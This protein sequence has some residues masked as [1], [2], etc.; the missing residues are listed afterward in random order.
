MVGLLDG[1]FGAEVAAA[2][3]LVGIVAI[4]AGTPIV[5]HEYKVFMG[6]LK[7]RPNRHG[8][9]VL[10]SAFTMRLIRA[11]NLEQH[12]ARMRFT[13]REVQP[14]FHNRRSVIGYHEDADRSLQHKD[15]WQH[16][17]LN[18][19]EPSGE[20]NT[21][22]ADEQTAESSDRE[23]GLIYF[24]VSGHQLCSGVEPAKGHGEG[25]Q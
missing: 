15:K 16:D 22:A 6:D 18:H 20:I 5:L 14:S 1:H 23:A 13:G 19:G 21:R 12:L 2:R 10:A 4:V 8:L 24:F 3:N 7:V 9:D 11:R 17:A 25:N